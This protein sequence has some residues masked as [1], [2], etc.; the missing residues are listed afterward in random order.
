MILRQFFLFGV[1]AAF[2]AVLST[3]YIYFVQPTFKYLGLVYH[4]APLEFRFVSWIVALLP[5]VWVKSKIERPSQCAYWLLYITVYVPSIIMPY[6]VLNQEPTPILGLTLG[7]FAAF[8]IL[9]TFCN[10]PSLNVP[11]LR[12]RPA[13]FYTLIFTFCVLTVLGVFAIY[14]VKLSPPSLADIYD[15]RS[16]FKTTAETSNPIGG[17]LVQWLIYSVAPLL[18]S[19]GLAYRKRTLVLLSFLAM[20]VIYCTLGSKTSFLLLP[21]AFA[22][23]K[24]VGTDGRNFGLKMLGAAT[25]VLL[26]TMTIDSFSGTKMVTG[27]ISMRMLH[28]PG[29]LSAYYFDFF[30]HN[31]TLGLSESFLKYFVRNPYGVRTP[32]LMGFE[33]FGD[34][35]IFSNVHVW[36]EAFGNFG[37]AGI[38]VF[39][40]ILGSLFWLYDS[41]TLHIDG[42]VPF[43]LFVIQSFGFANSGLFT[44]LLTGGFLI[45]LGITYLFRSA[46]LSN[47]NFLRVSRLPEPRWF[48]LLGERML[49]FGNLTRS[50]TG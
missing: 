43:F 34:S 41:L 42:R 39:T 21:L 46:W 37:Y 1:A 33:Y 38:F 18:F 4:P 23:I 10:L 12:L 16:E 8:L 9:W 36:G 31:P 35:N 5:L 32:N 15:V 28:V 13:T 29:I 47:P 24:V 50:I 26:V 7:M 30:S 20:W 49:S 27:I 45:N 48:D 17:Y 6:L 22:I 40:V 3:S 25:L 44:T 19:F 14:G 2:I 11:P